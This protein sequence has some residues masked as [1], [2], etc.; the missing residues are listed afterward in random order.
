M[1]AA[2]QLFRKAVEWLED[3]GKDM[4]AGDVFRWCMCRPLACGCL[5][6]TSGCAASQVR[7]KLDHCGSFGAPF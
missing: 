2:Q 4:L 7:G 5:G 1:Q 6:Y 3:E